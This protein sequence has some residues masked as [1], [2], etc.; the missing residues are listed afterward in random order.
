[1]LSTAQERLDDEIVEAH[2]FSNEFAPR[3]RI[4]QRA[5][6]HPERSQVRLHADGEGRRQT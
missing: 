6:A 4:V 5:K 1:M 2:S 3:L